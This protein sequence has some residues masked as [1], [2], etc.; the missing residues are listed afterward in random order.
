MARGTE[1]EDG[2]TETSM[3]TQFFLTRVTNKLQ[4]QTLNTAAATGVVCPLL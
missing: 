3:S 4:L 1:L 2:N